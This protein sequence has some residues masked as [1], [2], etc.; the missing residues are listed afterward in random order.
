MILEVR[1]LRVRLGSTFVLDGVSLS[2]GAGECVAVVGDSGSGKTTLALACMGLLPRGGR[3]V[4]GS[5]RFDG[6]ELVGAG[7]RE[8]DELRGRSMAML[9]Q[10]PAAALDP[11]QRVGAQVSETLEVHGLAR[12]PE[13]RGRV[14]EALRDAGVPNAERILG[15]V[16]HRLS[17]GLRQRVALASA[18]VARPRLLFADEPTTALDPPL[19]SHVL[20]LLGRLRRETGLAVVLISHDRDAVARHAQRVVALRRGRAAEAAATP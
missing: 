3:V 7:E 20:G 11:I 16:P 5:I 12:G 15:E 1:D 8:L 14:V 9:F 17:G 19:R 4:E 6:R 13:S 10:E 2:I 18:I